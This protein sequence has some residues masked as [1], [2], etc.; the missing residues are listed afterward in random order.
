MELGERTR[1]EILKRLRILDDEANS[2]GR[3]T[4]GNRDYVCFL[5]S[6]VPFRFVEASL[7]GHFH[8]PFGRVEIRNNPRG[9]IAPDLILLVGY[10]GAATT[11]WVSQWFESPELIVPREEPPDA[12]W[13]STEV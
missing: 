1:H 11:T 7:L 3:G 8:T 5:G 2:H 6:N 12:T 13:R 9:D 10:V 4:R